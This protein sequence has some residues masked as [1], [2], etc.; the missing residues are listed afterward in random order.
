[1]SNLFDSLQNKTFDIV[2]NTMGVNASWTPSEGGGELVGRVLFNDPSKK[3]KLM[4][5]DYQPAGWSIEYREGVFVGLYESVRENNIETITLN[6]SN[7]T[8]RAV[9]K[10][11][12]GKTYIAEVEQE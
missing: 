3:Y 5:V 11:F 9:T 2:G 12:D 8:V 6:G 10:D 4:G 7:Y 1:M